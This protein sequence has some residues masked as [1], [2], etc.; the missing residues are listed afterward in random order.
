MEFHFRLFLWCLLL[1]FRAPF[2]AFT[3]SQVCQNLHSQAPA[4]APKVASLPRLCRVLV[5]LPAG[6][7]G[8]AAASNLFAL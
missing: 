2:P 8:G 6:S 1:I 7:I 5:H 3:C 4:V